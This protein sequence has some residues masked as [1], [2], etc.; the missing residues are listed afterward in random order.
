MTR[1]ALFRITVV[2]LLALAIA[3]LAG[4]HA[5]DSGSVS[6]P[7]DRAHGGAAAIASIAP[8]NDPA[9]Q[10]SD[11]AVDPAT[12]PFAPRGWQ[13][14]AAPVAA[15]PVAI[16]PPVAA[17]PA[18][19]P[20]PLAPT[21]PYAFMGQFDD[22]GRRLVYLSRNDQTFVVA[23]GDTIE[24]AYKVLAMEP[25][26]I[27]FEHIATGARQSLTIAAPNN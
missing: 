3:T 27:E 1:G 5:D 16:P 15:P 18:P 24:G 12:D 4:G 2:A 17:A 10:G 19:A 9:P 23:Q 20:E 8:P 11:A 26:R 25:T 14:V 7:A 21:L 13:A 6:E 22:G